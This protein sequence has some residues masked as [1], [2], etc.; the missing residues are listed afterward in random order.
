MVQQLVSASPSLGPAL[1][2]PLLGLADRLLATNPCSLTQALY[3][4]LCSEALGAESSSDTP[5]VT[6]RCWRRH[7]LGC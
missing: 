5:S 4:E 3:I 6:R 2:R 7:W 1:A